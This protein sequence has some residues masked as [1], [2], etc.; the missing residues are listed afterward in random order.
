M[1][2]NHYKRMQTM[3]QCYNIWVEEGM[4]RFSAFG[5]HEI[6][7]AAEIYDTNFNQSVPNFREETVKNFQELCRNYKESKS[8]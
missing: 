4:E 5:Q 8:S 6:A 3:K 1:D 2:E 7:K